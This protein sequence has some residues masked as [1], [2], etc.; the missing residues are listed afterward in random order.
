[1]AS[2]TSRRTGVVAA[3]SRKIM[4]FPDPPSAGCRF[5]TGATVHVDAEFDIEAQVQGGDAV[6][7]PADRDDIHPGGGDPCHG[8]QVDVAAGLDPGPAGHQGHSRGKIRQG[9]VVQHD[10]VHPGGQHGFDLVHPVHLHLEV[11]GVPQPRLGRRAAP[12]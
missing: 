7:E 3:A 11:R 10:G 12:R 5:H 9:E 2:S 6:G 1:M 8:G 4:A